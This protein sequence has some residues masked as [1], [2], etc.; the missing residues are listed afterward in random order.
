MVQETI[1]YVRET[2]PRFLRR[3]QDRLAAHI[4]G[5]CHQRGAEIREQQMV[6]RAVGQHHSDVARARSDRLRERAWAARGEQD[7]PHGV[8]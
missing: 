4:T 1:G 7:R 5:S 3:R 8:A 6:Q 2:R